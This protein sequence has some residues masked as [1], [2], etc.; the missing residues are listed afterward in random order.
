MKIFITREIN[1]E[2]IEDMKKID[3]AE[4]IINP[5]DQLL[6]KNQIIEKAKGST[7]LVTLL[8]DKIDKEIIDALC[9]ELKIIA[10]Y[11]V[12]FDNIDFEFAKK[13]NVAVTNTPEV[14][15]QAVAE[16]AIALMLACSRRI[17]EGDKY[18]RAGKYSLWEPDLLLGPEIAGKTLG[19]V[20]MG[21]IGQALANIAY[22][23]F[24]MKILYHDINP[25]EEIERNLQADRVSLTSLFER[26]DFI[27]LHVPLLK[28]TKHMISK[29]QLKLMKKSAILV[30]TARG[31]IIDEEALI[32]AL[33]EK[34]IFAAG[35]DVFEKEGSVD[36]RLYKLDNVVLTPHIA[37]ATHEARLQMG[38]CI[39][40]NIKEVLA[41]KP[42]KTPVS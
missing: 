13:K 4:V 38:E 34:E 41:G 16:H 6:S 10:N 28:E 26:S 24:G 18:V 32:E 27:S 22:H 12:G 31:A 25:N 19:V 36:E 39:V 2:A 23:G 29:E 3:G 7:C 1:K 42:P 9:P 20:G 8:S 17:V 40:E 11:A 35:L 30:N 15:T 5:K 21:R 33:Q 14:M 37:S